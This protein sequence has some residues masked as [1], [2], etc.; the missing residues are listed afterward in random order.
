MTTT[1]MTAADSFWNTVSGGF[2]TLL[3]AGVDRLASEIN[4]TVQANTP[5]QVQSLSD[6]QPKTPVQT[7]PE[8]VQTPAQTNTPPP[9]K[10][11]LPKWV[12][13]AAAVTG[14]VVLGLLLRR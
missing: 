3:N 14:A 1:T 7:P 10:A 11:P 2:G 5:Q 9:P 8:P 4:P 12:V 6:Q 13:P